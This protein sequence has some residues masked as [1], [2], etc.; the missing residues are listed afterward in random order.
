MY[1]SHG[2]LSALWLLPRVIFLVD[3]GHKCS[4][5]CDKASV[6]TVPSLSVSWGQLA[7]LTGDVVGRLWLE[8]DLTT[9][10][11]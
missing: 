6:W 7:S 9:L 4:C 8:S 1:L 11:L 10:W 5:V 3:R 2:Q